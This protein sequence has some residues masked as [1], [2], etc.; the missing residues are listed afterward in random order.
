M[1]EVNSH[2]RAKLWDSENRPCSKARAKKCVHTVHK[3][4]PIQMSHRQEESFLDPCNA[5][6]NISDCHKFSPFHSK[7]KNTTEKKAI[8]WIHGWK[9]SELISGSTDECTFAI[10]SSRIVRDRFN[11]LFSTISRSTCI[12][13]K[14]PILPARRYPEAPIQPLCPPHPEKAPSPLHMYI[15]SPNSCYYKLES[16]IIN[17]CK[18]I[19]VLLTANLNFSN[20]SSM[21]EK[22]SSF[23]LK[24]YTLIPCVQENWI[25]EIK[26]LATTATMQEPTKQHQLH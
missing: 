14:P 15:L 23:N 12:L 25:R 4:L 18:E 5:P 9:L 3:W 19:W 10:F 1:V 11:S 16:N 7:I 26:L 21:C 6:V 17:A 8:N 24:M 2:I 22:N 20:S 13:S